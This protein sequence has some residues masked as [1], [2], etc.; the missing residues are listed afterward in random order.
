MTQLQTQQ[1]LSSR[2]YWPYSVL[3]ILLLIPFIY[4]LLHVVPEADD[5]CRAA[6]AHGLFDFSCGLQH[7]MKGWLEYGGR[8]THHF[9]VY[10]LGALVMYP[11]GAPMVCI[12]VLG[13]Y[14]IGF[15]G[16]FSTI[17]IHGMSGESFFGAT[18]ALLSLFASFYS[19]DTAYMLATDALGISIGNGFL[20]IVVW[21]LCLVWFLPSRR[22]WVASVGATFFGAAAAGCYEHATIA[23]AIAVTSAML[24]AMVYRH[25]NL[26]QF[27]FILAI[28]IAFVCA[29]LFAPGNWGRRG[30]TAFSL[31]RILTTVGEDAKAVAARALEWRYVVT[32]IAISCLLRP[33]WNQSLMARLS[34][35]ASLLAGA[36]GYVGILG[37]IVLL[38]ALADLRMDSAHKHIA[39]AILLGAYW[40]A[41]IILGCGAPLRRVF[42]TIPPIAIIIPAIAFLVL[43]P[44][45]QKTMVN[46][47]GG[48][49]LD[50]YR[51]QAGRWNW[52]KTRPGEDIVLPI[53]EITPYPV[54][55]LE[56]LWPHFSAEDWPNT[57]A[58]YVCGVK[59]VTRQPLSPKSAYE[60]MRVSY[61]NVTGPPKATGLVQ[62]RFFPSVQYG[63]NELFERDWLLLQLKEPARKVSILVLVEPERGRL[64][65][66][67]VQRWA[68]PLA[69]EEKQ[70]RPGFLFSL[71]GPI[72]TFDLEKWCVS[73]TAG[74]LY[75]LPVRKPTKRAI[76]GLYVSIDGSMF[77]RVL[78]SEQ[79]PQTHID[80]GYQE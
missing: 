39:S 16:I 11:W 68:T 14:W 24:M 33:R 8:Y 34:L 19:F 26:R 2:T 21:M 32:A 75:A 59:S 55:M 74:A 56:K 7:A 63:P 48:N 31:Q 60:A 67:W 9:L 71:L 30:H 52:A 50:F 78:Y 6:R 62:S 69:A 80:V 58:A 4:T 22:A 49:V 1:K 42:Q 70:F 12:G 64:V 79:T 37:C 77:E 15:F 66:K 65:P 13:I 17:S 28:T 3:T 36:V 25:P 41:F 46:A 44:L 10:A 57:D 40:V 38:H 51:I 76:L 61:N 53:P 35:P 43:S 5:F 54:Y 23:T 72:R 20:L 47:L 73:N 18:L 29:A 27:A 45:Y